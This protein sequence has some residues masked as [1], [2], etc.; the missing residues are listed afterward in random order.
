MRVPLLDLNGQLAP[1]RAEILAEITRVMDSSM[2]IMGPDVAKFEEN[3]A[4]YCQSPRGIGVSSGTDALLCALMGLGIGPGDKVLT[5][6][7]SFFATMGSVLRLGAT[8]V[9]ADIDPRTFNISPAKMR[10]LLSQGDKSIKAVIP[11]HLYGQCAA[12]DEIMAIAAEYDLPVVEDAAQAI[13]ACF[14]VA[15]AGGVRW[16]RAG[17]FGAVGCF[18]FFPSKNLGGMGDGG[19][20]TV[21]DEVLAEQLDVIR[22]HGGKPKYYHGVLGGNFRLDAIQAAILD[23]KLR[24]LPDWHKGR[25]RNAQIYEA[26]FQKTGL[27]EKGLVALPQAVYRALADDPVN[28][29]DYHI[30]NQFVIRVQDRDALR[31]YLLQHE[32]GAEIYYPVPLH[33]QECL[34]KTG[35]QGPALPET[36]KAAAETLALPIFPELSK[37]MLEFVVAQILEF[38]Q[39]RGML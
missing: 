13:G 2:Y 7:Y 36:D 1:I 19:M 34:V 28:G 31:D 21:Q 12:M 3:V 16:Q 33:R 24:Y 18:S 38:Y 35:W 29:A 15:E 25:R 11:V 14:P 22:V 10:E 8:P 9:F 37:D 32:V 6:S 5:S 27:V 30:Y 26:L 39:G 20:M 4:A 17:S 23:V